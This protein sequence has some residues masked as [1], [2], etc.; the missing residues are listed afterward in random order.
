MAKKWADIQ[1]KEAAEAVVRAAQATTL[2]AELEHNTRR[3]LQALDGYW[4]R[5]EGYGASEEAW[6]TVY[7]RYR[8]RV[9]EC[10]ARAAELLEAERR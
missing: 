8:A 6:W 9:E 4:E 3:M 1:H 5:Y 10:A 2:L 7:E